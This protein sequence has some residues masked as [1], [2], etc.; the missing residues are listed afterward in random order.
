MRKDHGGADQDLATRW[1]RAKRGCGVTPHC[2]IQIGGVIAPWALA[3][4]YW[5]IRSNSCIFDVLLNQAHV[6][7]TVG[8]HEQL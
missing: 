2:Q 6:H 1:L 3:R 4:S 5:K 8:K 7:G